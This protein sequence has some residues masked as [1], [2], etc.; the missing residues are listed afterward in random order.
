MMYAN[1][2]KS[3][4]AENANRINNAIK[5]IND[6][7]I[8]LQRYATQARWSAYFNQNLSREKCVEYTTNRIKK[9]AEKSLKAD[10]ASL[11]KYENAPT[12]EAIQINIDW[13]RSSVWGYNPHVT[14]RIWYEGIFDIEEYTAKA[15]GCNYDKRSHAV[16]SALNQCAAIKALLC[17][18]K[19]KEIENGTEIKKTVSG[20]D[21]NPHSSGYGAIPF[22][23][24]CGMSAIENLLDKCGFKLTKEHGT[25]TTD[26]YWF[27]RK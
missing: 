3:L 25:K 17:N 24:G 19:E 13:K 27:D 18:M 7:D 5:A 22:V 26:Y 10:M 11:E 1:I 23:D 9:E 21:I 16:A 6:N 4:Q 14:L 8:A 2:L 12:I 15:S 20:L